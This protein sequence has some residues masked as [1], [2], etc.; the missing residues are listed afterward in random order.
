V[1]VYNYHYFWGAIAAPADACVG[2]WVRVAGGIRGEFKI[3]CAMRTCI[4]GSEACVPL[5]RIKLS[6]TKTSMLP[7]VHGIFDNR[8][9]LI[10]YRK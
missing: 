5:Y 9:T 6:H 7:I 8:E 10:F 4:F 1:C 2:R 3:S